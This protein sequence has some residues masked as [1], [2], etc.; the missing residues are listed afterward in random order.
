MKIESFLTE[1]F[2][3]EYEFSSPH[4]LAS[5]DCETLSINEL[6]S[7][8][9]ST[10]D[11]LASLTLGYTESQGN[12]ALRS[13]IAE[14]YTSIGKDDVVFL[15]SPVEGIYL[16]MQTLL[17][18]NDEAVALRPAYDALSNVARHLCRKVEPWSLIPTEDK[19]CLDF[20]TLESMIRPEMKVIIV[21][22]PHNPTGFLPTKTEF[23]RLIEIAKRHDLWLFCDEIYRGLEFDQTIPSAADSYEKSITLSGLSKT[24]GLPGLRAGWLVVR[25]PVVRNELINWKHYTTICP[26]APTEF[27][28]S[29]ALKV[30]EQLA[31][32]S[33]TIIEKNIKVC[34]TFFTRHK[35]LFTWRRPVAGSVAFVEVNLERLE[36]TS[37]EAFCH[38]LAREKGIVLL[39]GNC[40]GYDI[41]FV[42]IGL[43]RLSFESALAALDEAL[44]EN[45]IQY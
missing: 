7:L 33:K 14:M 6:L 30:R 32:R 20:E 42:R 38:Y 45:P 36:C 31:D 3:S 15:T 26:A 11:E 8:S 37:V 18:P 35:H 41:P 13:Q 19:W 12:P 34:E 16:A 23:E 25:D 28:A 1:H 43:G 44:Q 2:F 21:N 24:H 39:P 4:L 27:L 5:S 10:T 22:F 17:E 40:L 29:E 9:G